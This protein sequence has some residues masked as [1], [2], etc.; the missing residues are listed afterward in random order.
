MFFRD[1]A[2]TEIARSFSQE[3]VLTLSNSED[4]GSLYKRK[5]K[6]NS[7]NPKECEKVI[8]QEIFVAL[9][10]DN[11]VSS[12]GEKRR[13]FKAEFVA[14]DGTPQEETLESR[15]AGSE[16]AFA[17]QPSQNDSLLVE[18]DHDS[19]VASTACHSF[20]AFF[21]NAF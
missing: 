17:S 9:S 7:S 13:T 8:T 14:N 15:S 11:S 19:G 10:E 2:T 4:G 16:S 5:I 6:L 12:S 18:F 3:I 1:D 21:C 20:S